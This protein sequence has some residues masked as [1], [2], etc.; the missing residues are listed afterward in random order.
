M[1]APNFL[2]HE[3]DFMNGLHKIGE[4]LRKITNAREKTRIFLHRL[5]LRPKNNMLNET[6][7]IFFRNPVTGIMSF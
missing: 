5:I 6:S 2:K 1:E 7:I 3:P 4:N